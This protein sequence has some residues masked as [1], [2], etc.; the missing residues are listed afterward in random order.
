M[1]ILGGIG[2]DTVQEAGRV[3]EDIHEN[4]GETLDGFFARLRALLEDYELVIG[5]RRKS[6]E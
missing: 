3:A 2:K 6:H 5:F 1:P 4:V